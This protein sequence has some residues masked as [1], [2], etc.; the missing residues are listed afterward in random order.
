MVTS[1]NRSEQAVMEANS[2]GITVW[3]RSMLVD[4]LSLFDGYSP[5]SDVKRLTSDLQAGTHDS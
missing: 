2:N 4:E 1:S 5:P 3:N